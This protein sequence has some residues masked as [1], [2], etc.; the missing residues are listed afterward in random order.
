MRFLRDEQTGSVWQQTTGIAIFGPLKGKQLELLHSDELTFALWRTEQPLGR[1]LKPN[2]EFSNLYD[3]KD[4]ERYIG[5]A[6]SVIDTKTSGIMPRELMLGVATDSASKAFPW[7][8]VLSAKLIQ[9]R[10]G[11]D[12][13]LVIIG[14]DNLSVRA[15]HTEPNTTFLRIGSGDGI[16]TDQET[17]SI[18]NFSACAISG[19]LSGQCL[20]PIDVKKD[21]GFDWLNYHPQTTVFRS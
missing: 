15:F 20:R 16:M 10:V 3:P 11:S 7:R 6:P 19:P 9:D 8:T 21:Y 12:P 5:K 17:S 1:I 14:P 4:W 18:W 13:V 2:L